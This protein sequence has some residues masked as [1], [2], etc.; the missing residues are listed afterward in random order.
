MPAKGF[1]TTE[2]IPV[3]RRIVEQIVG[4]DRAV[5]II[6]KAARQKRNALLIGPPGCGKSLL[7]QAMAELLPVEKLEDVLSVHNPA[8][9]NNPKIVVVPAGEGKKR[10]EEE[11]KKSSESAL[12]EFK[13]N[14]G[15]F[16]FISVLFTITIIAALQFKLFSDTILA[17]FII[18]GG[19][20]MGLLVFAGAFVSGMKQFRFGSKENELAP[21][22]LMD[23]SQRNTAPFVEATGAHSGALFGDVL[24]DP[25]QTFFP[26]TTVY[27][28]INNGLEPIL[29][30][31]LVDELL[32]KYPSLVDHSIEGYEGVILPKEE[33][34]FVLGLKEGKIWP[35]RLL[36]VNRRKYN[37]KMTI[38]EDGRNRLIVTPEHEVYNNGGYIE[39]QKISPKT[40][41]FVHDEDIITKEDL[42]TTFPEKNQ[43]RAKSYYNFVELKKLNPHH[44][45]RRMAKLLG[46]SAGRTRWW[47]SINSKPVAIKIIEKL[48]EKGLIPL[49]QNDPRLPTIARLLGTA[50]GDGGIQSNINNFFLSSAEQNSL[51]A[52]K[53]DIVDVFGSEVLQNFTEIS[54]GIKK[55]GKCIR[56]ANRAVVRFFVALGAPVGRKNK[57]IEIPPW[58]Y[59]T[60][61]TQKEFFG[62]FFGNELC[63]PKF[64]EKHHYLNTFDVAVCGTPEVR[65]NRIKFL[66][67]IERFLN[68]YDIKCTSIYENEF[69][70]NSFMWKL[71]ISKKLENVLRFKQ[72]IPIRYSENKKKRLETAVE[73]MLK[74][75]HT[76]YE[77]LKIKKSEKYIT[78][79]LRAPIAMLQTMESPD[80]YDNEINFN[81]LIYNITTES[82]NLFAN[83]ILAKNSGG[84]GTPAHVRVQPGMIHRAHKGV[85]FIDEI[86]A[87][88][89][90]SQQELLTAMQEKKYA[91]TGQSEMS[92]GAMV[93]TEPVPCDFI[94]VASGNI[95]DIEK[96]HPALRSRIRGYGYEIYL[97]EFLDETEKNKLRLEQF[98]AQEVVK[99]GKIPHFSKDAV[100]EIIN[101]AKKRAGRKKKYTMRLRDLGGLIR[102]AGDIAK[103]KNHPAVLHGDVT[104]AKGFAQ[105]LEQQVAEKQIIM[106]KE[107]E[108]IKTTG[109]MRGR[110][111]GLAVMGDGTGQMGGLMLPIEAEVAPAQ[112]TA[113]GKII[114]TGKLG[115][116]AK[117]AVQNVSAI[118]KKYKGA[119]ISNYDI[120]IQ[121][122]QTYEGVEGDSASIS[123]ATAVLS[124]LEGIAVN[125]NVAMTGSLSVR[126]EVLPV[127]GITAKI[128]AALEA[129]AKTVIIPDANKNDIVLHADRLKKIKIV[130][131]K[132]ICDVLR[133]ALRESKARDELIKQIRK[134]IEA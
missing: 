47:Y 17:A 104:E 30:K 65:E 29:I 33:E 39:A 115:D 50:F 25:L 82:G 84:L 99:D 86:A 81:G 121:F 2:E 59:L 107:Y 83:G 88:S 126:G 24:H 105:T 22:L 79:T 19:L 12:A 52:F 90:K 77:T 76:S 123:V 128:E 62:A 98:V 53:Q 67:Q 8:D 45:Y 91:I 133:V 10:I 38:L 75:K 110:V 89:P 54:S 130:P 72:F 73:E 92:S 7:A 120:H 102:A 100:E 61:E 31:D 32:E 14:I 42:F 71:C 21:K 69:R 124:A 108:V 119:N 74:W 46:V 1:K 18:V 94:L 103:T 36:C 117:E 49:K 28:S 34:M 129:G 95:F 101:E 118:I 68:S 57:C 97:N 87:L 132:T 6:K 63:S 13:P 27:K 5:E 85:L 116:I 93:R 43:E 70:K 131:A 60:K 127:G 55:T 16:F 3:P 41:L 51:D 15:S 106:K 78:A 20:F 113:E 37:G 26:D 44:G 40:P 48:E 56:N 66:K 112:S 111:N 4:Q 80:F 109:F 9:P 134:I 11:R 23:N 114:A 122:L 64:S 125:Q 35:T 96:M 58:I